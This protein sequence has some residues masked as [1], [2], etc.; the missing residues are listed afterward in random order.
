MALR[1]LVDMPEDSDEEPA[2]IGSPVATADEVE[3]EVRV[4]P[5]SVM[6]CVI[7]DLAVVYTECVVL[8]DV[9][10]VV[11]S[12]DEVDCGIVDV[13]FEDSVAGVVV[14]CGVEEGVVETGVEETGVDVSEDV[15]GTDSLVGDSV[16]DDDNSVTGVS[17]TESVADGVVTG[18]SVEEAAPLPRPSPTERS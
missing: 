11:S 10:V 13:G 12:G 14:C 4:L 7:V 6:T 8:G 15:G 1:L 5:F 9:V 18:A 2:S 17:V 16:I 3:R